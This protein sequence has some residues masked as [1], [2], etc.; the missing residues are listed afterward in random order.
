ML[1]RHDASNTSSPDLGQAG[2][3]T[4]PPAPHPSTVYDM[5]D[6]WDDDVRAYDGV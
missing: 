1:T 3:S 2:P 5:R 6:D 4:F